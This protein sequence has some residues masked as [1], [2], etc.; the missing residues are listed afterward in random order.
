MAGKAQLRK[1]REGTV[2]NARSKFQDKALGQ[3]CDW[4]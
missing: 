3:K 4:I 2:I 1:L